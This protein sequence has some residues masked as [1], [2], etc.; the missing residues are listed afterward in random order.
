[1]GEVYCISWQ[2]RTIEVESTVGLLL[3]SERFLQAANWPWHRA[4]AAFCLP[5]RLAAPPE[6]H[7]ASLRPST[8]GLWRLRLR[9][10][11]VQHRIPTPSQQQHL[12]RFPRLRLRSTEPL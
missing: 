5:E 7:A 12:R 4:Y 3:T 11:S 1:M 2:L 10:S 9:C 8:K 6:P